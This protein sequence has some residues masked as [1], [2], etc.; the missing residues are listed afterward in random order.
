M[1]ESWIFQASASLGDLVWLD[2]ACMLTAIATFLSSCGTLSVIRGH[3]GCQGQKDRASVMR[4]LTQCLLSHSAEKH[5]RTPG[6]LPG[7]PR[8]SRTRNS[9]YPKGTNA[10]KP[11]HPQLSLFLKREA[12]KGWRPVFSGQVFNTGL[13]SMFSLCFQ[14]CLQSACPNWWCLSSQLSPPDGANRY[15][16]RIAQSLLSLLWDFPPNTTGIRSLFFLQYIAR[17]IP[18]ITSWGSFTVRVYCLDPRITLFLRGHTE[19][20]VLSTCFRRH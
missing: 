15:F 5:S 4:F 12:I 3:T 16:Y 6:H 11:S 7:K 2:F 1:W 19:E 13:R 8:E 20:E 10:R 9:S 18:L 17:I 14:L